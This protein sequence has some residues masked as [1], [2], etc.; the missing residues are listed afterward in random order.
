MFELVRMRDA[1]GIAPEFLDAEKG[2]VQDEINKKYANRVLDGV[3][4]VVGL[5]NIERISNG[6]IHPGDGA[7]HVTVEFL[8][9][10]FKPHIGEVL[11]GSITSSDGDGLYVSLGFFDDVQIP[12]SCLPSPSRFDEEEKCW[13]WEWNGNDMWLDHGQEI[14]F[15]VF[16]IE[17]GP[18]DLLSHRK[19]PPLAGA[20]ESSS[21]APSTEVAAPA[22]VQPPMMIT[23]YINEPG[24]GL[25]CWWR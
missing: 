14:Q 24:L 19:P 16:S 1:V 5:Y 9:I 10:V 12:P 11:C 3:G 8:L 22:H 17:Y 4:L 7:S 15:R 6:I 20:S 21:A 25:V 18:R 23:G 2:A 13:V